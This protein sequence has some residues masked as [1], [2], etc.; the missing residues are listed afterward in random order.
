LEEAVTFTD[1]LEADAKDGGSQYE[2]NVLNSDEVMKY[3][4]DTNPG[5]VT[6]SKEDASRN[7]SPA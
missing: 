1:P 4:L 6:Q 2:A 3:K 7:I 5:Q